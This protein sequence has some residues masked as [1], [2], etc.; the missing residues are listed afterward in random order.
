MSRYHVL[1]FR[2]SLFHGEETV[3]GL[4][5]LTEYSIPGDAHSRSPPSNKEI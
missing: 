1:L 3:F 2:S 4:I 5:P